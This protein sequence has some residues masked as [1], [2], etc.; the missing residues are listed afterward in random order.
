MKFESKWNSTSSKTAK[1]TADGCTAAFWLGGEGDRFG[2]DLPSL[3]IQN[4]GY[5]IYVDIIKKNILITL[6]QTF[7]TLILS[8]SK[9]LGRPWEQLY[10]YHK[11]PSIEALYIGKYTLPVRLLKSKLFQI[12]Y[13]ITLAVTPLEPSRDM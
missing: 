3:N 6:I 8:P 5:R 13:I 2:G 10:L 1:A 9:K 4:N 7:E 12:Y 11:L